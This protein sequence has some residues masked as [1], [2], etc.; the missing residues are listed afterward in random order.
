MQASI[1]ANIGHKRITSANFF[2]RGK[3]KAKGRNILDWNTKQRTGGERERVGRTKEQTRET[4]NLEIIHSFSSNASK[5]LLENQPANLWTNLKVRD[6]IS[7]HH[8][9]YLQPTVKRQHRVVPFMLR[10]PELSVRVVAPA[11]DLSNGQQGASMIIS[12][13]K[14]DNLCP[15]GHK[16]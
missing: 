8:K 4:L 10:P 13:G 11:A 2:A 9:K 6:N 1:Q 16:H 14:G 3:R 15:K 12:S 5:T 7:S